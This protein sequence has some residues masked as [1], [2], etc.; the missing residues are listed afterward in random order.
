MRVDREAQPSH[1]ARAAGR[2]VDSEAQPSH[3]ARVQGVS[4]GSDLRSR[5]SQATVHGGRV[6]QP[7]ATADNARWGHGTRMCALSYKKR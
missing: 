5:I 7:R 4:T 6:Q 1:G 2:Q 3:G